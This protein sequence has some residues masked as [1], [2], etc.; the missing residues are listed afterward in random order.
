MTTPLIRRSPS[1]SR[2][3]RGAT[4]RRVRRGFTLAEV[5]VAITLLVLVS[6]A[7]LNMVLGN[8][9]SMRSQREITAIEDDLRVLEQTVSIALRSAG[10]NPSR[11]TG[12][13][14]GVPRLEGIV[15]SVATQCRGIIAIS[16]LNADRALDGPLEYLRV[17]Q[18]GETITMNRTTNVANSEVAQDLVRTL[19]FEFL[20][21]T[22]AAVTCATSMP[23]ARQV[24]VTVEARR[25]AG[26]DQLITRQWLVQL[27]NFQ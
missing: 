3:G 12:S 2:R 18:V 21:G 9:R 14:L 20:T 15:G 26:S 5:V 7:A 4:P 27:R 1:R 16:D 8:S 25:R 13:T 11:M 6:G 24:R 23:T 10:A 17:E 19:R 22:G